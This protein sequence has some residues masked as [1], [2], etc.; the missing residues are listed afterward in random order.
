MAQRQEFRLFLP[1]DTRLRVVCAAS[2]HT[3]P[4][5]M[6]EE[7]GIGL[8]IKGGQISASGRGQVVSEP[9]NIITLNPGEVHDGAPIGH[10]GREWMMIYMAP[11]FLGDLKTG[12]QASGEIEFEKPVIADPSLSQR[13]KRAFRIVM[14]TDQPMR[15]LALEEAMLGLLAPVLARRGVR[16]LRSTDASLQKVHQMICDD[17]TANLS[18][19][20]MARVANVSR[21]QILRAFQAMTGLTPHAFILNRRAE[22][23]RRMIMAGVHLAESAAACG[24]ADQS[25]MTRE[26]KKRYGLRPAAFQTT[27]I[28]KVE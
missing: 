26:F 23:A 24:Y 25:H 19:E 22:L 1:A 20:D 5:H 8:L 13:F 15:S 12:W 3:F 16:H 7:F 17:P 10:H 9:G 18:L 27:K 4:R 28:L 11:E 2:N 14:A 6:H 21:F